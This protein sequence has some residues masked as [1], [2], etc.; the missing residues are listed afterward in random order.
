MSDF[1]NWQIFGNIP[2]S[3]FTLFNM[4]ALVEDSD[5]VM[6]AVMEKQPQYTIVLVGFNIFATLGVLSVMI[7]VIVDNTMETSAS[8]KEEQIVTEKSGKLERISQPP[9]R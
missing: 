2:R 6:R 7:G 1:N 9:R 8:L 3:M 5:I 4:A